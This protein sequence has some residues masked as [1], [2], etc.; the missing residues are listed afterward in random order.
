MKKHGETILSDNTHF[1]HSYPNPLNVVSSLS[2]NIHEDCGRVLCSPSETYLLPFLK[3]INQLPIDISPVNI[4]SE[5]KVYTEVVLTQTLKEGLVALQHGNNEKYQATNASLKTLSYKAFCDEKTTIPDFYK[6]ILISSDLITWRSDENSITLTLKVH[7]NGEREFFECGLK[8]NTAG[9]KLT[10]LDPLT[11][12][13]NFNDNDVKYPV[14]VT[15]RVLLSL[16]DL[17]KILEPDI[18]FED[19]LEHQHNLINTSDGLI[20]KQTLNDEFN[21]KLVTADG[22][23]SVIDDLELFNP[24]LTGILESLLRKEEFLGY[25]IEFGK[26]DI[27]DFGEIYSYDEGA[28]RNYFVIRFT[29]PFYPDDEC[30]VVFGET[31]YY[32]DMP[33]IV[34]KRPAVEIYENMELLVTEED[35]YEKT[36]LSLLDALHFMLSATGLPKV[37]FDT[38]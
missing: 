3:A 30:H 35:Y 11:Y 27:P 25:L 4:T 12:E 22:L 34:L 2:V 37:H 28:E 1:S 13:L 17:D 18:T 31:V 26:D 14:E 29:H 5:D 36:E 9:W 24:E 6:A 33:I 21:I 16:P 15:Q 23:S 32:P 8:L 38:P 10:Q 7:T 20:E 19:V